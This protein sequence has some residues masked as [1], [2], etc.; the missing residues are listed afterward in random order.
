MKK[1]ILV[2]S[3]GTT[4]GDTRKVTIDKIEEKIRDTFVEYDIRRAFTSHVILKVLKNRDNIYID[5]PEEA[6]EK[7]KI[8][9][10]NEVI[11]QPLHVIPGVEFDYINNVVNRYKQSKV[12]DNIVIGRPLICFKGEENGV[13]DDYSIMLDALSKQ[14]PS[15]ETVILMGHG[16]NHIANAVYCCFESVLRDRGF[17][18]VHVATVEGYPTLDRVIPN[19]IAQ[20][21]LEVSLMPL[22]LVAGD[23]AKNDMA[24]DSRESWKSVLEAKGFKVKIYMQGLGENSEIQDIYIQH[25]YDVINDKFNNVGKTLKGI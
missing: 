2:V 18:N 5:T 12:F 9:G 22:L 25:I 3:F 19:V 11:V 7:L 10:Y 23:H 21:S 20:G 16:T 14:L 6:L 8:E 4:Y 15:N 17:G 1:A 13:P 24:G